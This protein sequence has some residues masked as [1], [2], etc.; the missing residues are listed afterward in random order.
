MAVPKPETKG[1][2]LAYATSP[3]TPQAP[4]EFIYL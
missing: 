4:F 1:G 3:V 2:V